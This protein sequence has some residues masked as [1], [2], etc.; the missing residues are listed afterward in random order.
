MKD[1]VSCDLTEDF[2]DKDTYKNRN[3]N[4]ERGGGYLRCN[5]EGLINGS[6]GNKSDGNRPLFPDFNGKL[7]LQSNEVLHARK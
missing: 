4:R 7:R 2:L 1:E 3:R 6:S 5:R